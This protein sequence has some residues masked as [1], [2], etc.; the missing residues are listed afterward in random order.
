[1]AFGLALISAR[2]RIKTLKLRLAFHS[3]CS[4]HLSGLGIS[5]SGEPKAFFDLVHQIETPLRNRH[6]SL[7]LVGASRGAST[8]N[9]PFANGQASAPTL[10]LSFARLPSFTFAADR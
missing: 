9:R 2:V 10:P 1:M 6:H 4:E 7:A 3:H 8:S 5:R